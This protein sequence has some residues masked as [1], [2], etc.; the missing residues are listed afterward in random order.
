M[1]PELT[2]LTLA[3]LLQ[4]VQFTLM[5][6]AANLDLGPGKTASPRDQSRLGGPLEAQL[7]DRPARL[8]RAFSN[9]F[10]SLALFA[11][12]CIVIT[13]SGQSGPFTTVCAWVYL[14]G[15]VLYIPAYYFGWVP[16]RSLIWFVSFVAATLILIAAL[17]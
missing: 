10:E 14:A 5:S 16:W 15:R 8:Y 7:S 17:T 6:V 4:V 11:I 9:H 13:V 12:G 2:V 3:A 1:T